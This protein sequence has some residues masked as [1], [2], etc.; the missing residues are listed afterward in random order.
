MDREANRP[1]G[2]S[3][4]DAYATVR[5]REAQGQSLSE[6]CALPPLPPLSRAPSWLRPSRG[7]TSPKDSGVSYQRPLPSL[8]F[9]F[10]G[11]PSVTVVHSISNTSVASDPATEWPVYERELGANAAFTEPQN[12]PTCLLGHRAERTEREAPR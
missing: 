6:H 11:L 9:L 5:T 3:P 4:P 12:P 1:A 2:Q 7:W 10:P 8:C